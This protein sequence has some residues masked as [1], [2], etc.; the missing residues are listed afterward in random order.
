M[1][2]LFNPSMHNV[3]QNTF[4]ILQ[5]RKILKVLLAKQLLLDSFYIFTDSTSKKLQILQISLEPFRICSK[6]ALR[7]V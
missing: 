7:M 3:D 5:H 6:R 2:L 1:R 4:K